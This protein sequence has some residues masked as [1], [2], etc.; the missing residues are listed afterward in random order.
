MYIKPMQK[1]ILYVYLKQ[2][3]AIDL[4]SYKVVFYLLRMPHGI[5]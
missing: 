2:S 3:Y 5:S 4:G 1:N